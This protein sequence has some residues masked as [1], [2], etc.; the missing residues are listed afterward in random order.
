MHHTIIIPKHHPYQV[1]FE[2]HDD[3]FFLSLA[4]IIEIYPTRSM[5]ASTLEKVSK[6]PHLQLDAKVYHNAYA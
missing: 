3:D 1:A 5:L 4:Y 6:S 2:L